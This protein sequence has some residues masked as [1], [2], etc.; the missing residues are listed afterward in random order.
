MA[1]FP[2]TVACLLVIWAAAPAVPAAAH[3]AAQPPKDLYLAKRI[4]EVREATARYRDL[5]A[6]RAAG[7][8]QAT[9][10]L[11]LLGYRFAHPGITA[12]AFDGP[13]S[14][15]YVKQGER[16]QLAGVEYA[17]AGEERPSA[18]PFAGIAWFRE[19][20]VCRYADWHELEGPARDQCPPQHPEGAP[21]A[22]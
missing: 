17:V 3:F 18:Q 8:V 6:A 16:W 1:P 5:A 12:F 21:L 15:I 14:L 10:N 4:A 20:A 19:A 13:S 22:A 2:R 11:P 7:Y 9:G